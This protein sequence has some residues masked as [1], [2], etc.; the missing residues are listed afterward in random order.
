MSRSPFEVVEKGR[1]FLRF[2]F[3]LAGGVVVILGREAAGNAL[4]HV[5]TRLGFNAN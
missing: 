4:A 1:D 3:M 5:K 2:A